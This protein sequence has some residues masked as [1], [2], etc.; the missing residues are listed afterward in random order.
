MPWKIP[1][2]PVFKVAA[3]SNC[4]YASSGCLTTDQTHALILNKMVECTDR[5]GTTTDTGKH[6]I[7]KSAFLLHDL[8]LNLAADYRLEITHDRRKWIWSHNRTKHIMRIVNPA[9]PLTECL[10][11]RIFQSTGSAFLLHVPS[12]QA[13]ASGIRFNA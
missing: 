10:G 11:D 12:R 6:G 13:D 3:V 2:R 4:I 9:C 1:R 7:R 5:I 8:L